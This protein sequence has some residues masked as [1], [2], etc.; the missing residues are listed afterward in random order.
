[1]CAVWA[2][3]TNLADIGNVV[4]ANNGGVP[5]KV[6]T[7]ARWRSSPAPRLGQ[8]SFMD[9]GRRGERSFSCAPVNAAEIVKKCAAM[10]DYL[11]EHVLR[12]D[13]RIHPYSH[14]TT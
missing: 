10:T 9:P 1:M 7:W 2:G 13:V 8:F 11:N 14:R 4:V 3:F 5:V 12:R 6:A